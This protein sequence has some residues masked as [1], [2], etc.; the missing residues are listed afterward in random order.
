MCLLRRCLSLT[1]CV[2]GCRYVVQ[3]MLGQGT[4]G[5]VVEC[6]REDH[7]HERLAVKVIKN[8]QAYFQQ[9]SVVTRRKGHMLETAQDDCVTSAMLTQSWRRPGLRTIVVP[10]TS[11]S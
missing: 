5:Q 11:V 3:C 4:F 6:I 2:F 7:G 10:V 1:Q 9:V 8:Q